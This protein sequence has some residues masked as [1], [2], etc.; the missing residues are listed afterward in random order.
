MS[1]FTK[2][3]STTGLIILLL[4][5]IFNVAAAKIGTAQ[6]LL[7]DT[8][9][10]SAAQPAWPEDS[11]GRRTPRGT[12]S[13]FISAVAKENYTRAARYLHIDRK[14]RKKRNAEKLAQ[15]LQQLLDQNASILPYALISEK[16][17]GHLDDNLG[18]NLDKVGTAIINNES[19]DIIVE[20]T[21]D[22]DGAPLWLFSAQTVESIP[23]PVEEELTTPLITK[24]LPKAL[25]EKKWG[26]V[27]I[28]HWI[29]SAFL[30]FIAYFLAWSVTRILIF[31]LAK[32]WKA[33]RVEPTAGIVRAF[34]RPVQL[35]LAVWFFV[36]AT[37]QADISIIVRQRLSSLSVIFYILAFLLL[38][39]QLLDAGS[40]IT[41]RNLAKRGNQAGV[42]AILFLRRAAKIAMV[43][44]AVIAIL[45]TIGFNV[46]T[47]IAALGIG[48]IALA[49]GAQK[50]VENFVGSVTLIADQPVR[51][52]DFCRVGQVVG[53]VEQIG[54]RS[55][56]IRTN[57]RTIVT[58]PNGEFSSLQI[59][60]F[61]HR[62]KF[63]FSPSFYF[64][65]QTTTDQIRY[66]LVEMRAV[67]YAH[68][69]VD[70]LPARIRFVSVTADGLK[71]EIFA[72]INA[73][74]FDMFLEVQEDLHL[75]LMD[76]IRN[77][78]AT[79]ALPSQNV[80]VGEQQQTSSEKQAEI[81]EQ[82]RAW[83]ADE[84]LQLPHFDADYIE[85]LK[86]KINYPPTGSTSRKPTDQK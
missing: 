62:D 76:V 56:Q 85:S 81:A 84:N 68:P 13:G 25:I 66:L 35:F 51:V 34:S 64:S 42:S 52:G 80:F 50:T 40:K 46:T 26:G 53:T 27:P 15:S 49:L 32:I 82:V 45:D 36:F 23:V 17:E 4:S 11:L 16:Y 5:V 83:T 38:I 41:Q 65:L 14:L 67:L 39:W 43:F 6:T 78:G 10:K 3:R 9:A 2:T 59:E 47:G 20:S 74:D 58:I 69:K 79:L 19:F 63:F 8:A 60:N 33:A 55:T 30:V 21:Q 29:I 44:V 37:E 57:E 77:S 48:G 72:Y 70:Q 86:G 7:P 28:G 54:M 18:P 12:V 22:K 71:F 31:L 75:H 61:T 24:I 73:V 1:K